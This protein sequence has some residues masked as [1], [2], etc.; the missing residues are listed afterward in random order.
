MRVASRW[1]ARS[2]SSA[3]PC[4]ACVPRTEKGVVHRD[5]KPA[6]IMIQ[7]GAVYI[8]DFGIVSQVEGGTVM[9]M[10]GGVVGTVDYMAP[11]QA[12]AER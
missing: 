7:E 5:L 1:R 10:V 9:T 11:E 6:N 3:R 8:M 12:K 2:P 4:L